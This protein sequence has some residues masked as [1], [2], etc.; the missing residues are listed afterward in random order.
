MNLAGGLL[1]SQLEAKLAVKGF[2]NPAIRYDLELDQLDADLYLPKKA[3]TAEKS[4]AAAEPEQP[5]DLTFLQKLN[6]EGGLR[7]GKLKVANVQSAK[8]RVDVKAHNGQLNVSPISAELYQGS[9]SGSI[10]I[11]AAQKVPGFAIKQSL[12]GIDIGPLLKDAVNLDMLEGKGDVDLNITTQG[13]TVSALKKGLNGAAAINLADGAVKGVNIARKLRE[14]GKGGA[15]T[16]TAN[17][18]EKTDF[19]EMKATFRVKNGV[20]HNE[21]LSLKSPLLRLSGKGDIDIG[22]DSIN[23]LAKATLAGTLEGQGGKD[24][25]G[26]ITVPVRLLGPYSDLKYK[27]EFGSL[28]SDSARQKVESKKE[29]LKSKLQDQL[30]GFLK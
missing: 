21:D 26:G 29:E 1:Q 14:F 4:E 25:V 20:A 30:K 8:L 16:E 6:L 15:D 7:I 13:N 24:V 17:K 28:I 19:S 27:F 12:E 18:N 5:F 23:Y 10:A 9:V 2:A 11:N 3:A 22:N